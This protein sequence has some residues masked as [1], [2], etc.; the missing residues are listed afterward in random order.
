M[1]RRHRFFLRDYARLT[2]AQQAAFKRALRLFL[3]GLIQQAFDPG[4]R[5]KRVEGYP[6]VWE[7]TWAPDGRATF[8]YGVEAR[9]GDPH[10]VWRRIGKHDTFREP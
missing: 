8:H 2:A 4:L 7:M 6:G 9:H 10:I 3:Q 5:I 1:R